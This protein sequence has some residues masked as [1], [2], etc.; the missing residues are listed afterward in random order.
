MQY[1]D[2]TGMRTMRT[3]LYNVWA[4][5]F[6]SVLIACVTVQYLFSI[7]YVGMYTRTVSVQYL[8][9][10]RVHAHCMQ[11]RL[12]GA[13]MKVRTKARKKLQT[14]PVKKTSA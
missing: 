5:I 3:V 14:V 4:Y 7:C 12:F 9:R 8:L 10:W 13:N 1:R 11:I 6:V 2:P